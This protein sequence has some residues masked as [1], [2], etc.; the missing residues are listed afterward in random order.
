MQIDITQIIIVGCTLLSVG[1]TYI[2]YPWIIKLGRPN[3][4]MYVCGPVLV[5]RQQKYYLKDLV[6]G[7]KN[8][9]ML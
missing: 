5:Y 7:V 3:G 4:I 1:V 8:G 9:I 2:I 6:R